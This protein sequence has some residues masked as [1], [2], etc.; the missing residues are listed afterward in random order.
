MGIEELINEKINDWDD[1]LNR[2][3][4]GETQNSDVLIRAALSDMEQLKS[5]LPTQQD[6]AVVPP[7]IDKYL[8]VGN[9]AQKLASL[10]SNK[11]TMLDSD[12]SDS[13]LKQ[14]L[15]EISMKDLL[16]LYNGYTVEKEQLYYV[17]LPFNEGNHI[18]TYYLR[19]GKVSGDTWFGSSNAEYSGN[20]ARLAEQEIKDHDERY[21]AFAVPVEEESQ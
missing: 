1:C 17:R 11:Y 8:N 16:S 14:W 9:K 21:W 18:R 13:E 7:M 12:E 6:K 20:T 5:S 2:H 4:G 15:K 10:V 3:Y 19:K